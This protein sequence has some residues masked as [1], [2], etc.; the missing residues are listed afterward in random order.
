MSKKCQKQVLLKALLT[1]LLLSN[2]V[3][4]SHP[5]PHGAEV[6]LSQD[7]MSDQEKAS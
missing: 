5:G 3:P 6:L 4:N 7:V 1:P 2:G